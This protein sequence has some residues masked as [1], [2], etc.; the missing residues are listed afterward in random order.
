MRAARGLAAAALVLVT[1]WN[2]WHLSV[3]SEKT[4]LELQHPTMAGT[5]VLL[6]SAVTGFVWWLVSRRSNG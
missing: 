5:V 6:V 3:L 4:A 1:G 2:W